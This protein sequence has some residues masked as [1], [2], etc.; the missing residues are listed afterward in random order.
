MPSIMIQT[1]NNVPFRVWCNT[2]ERWIHSDRCNIDG[3][4]DADESKPAYTGR[5]IPP[6][7][8]T[9]HTVWWQPADDAKLEELKATIKDGL[10]AGNGDGEWSALVDAGTALGLVHD[11]DTNSYG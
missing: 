1:D 2:C 9:T 5:G 11:E 10:N 6:P 8:K 4:H 3:T 7:E